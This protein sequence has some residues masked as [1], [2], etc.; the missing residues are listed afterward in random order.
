[1]SAP[2]QLE[3]ESENDETRISNITKLSTEAIDLIAVRNFYEAKNRLNKLFPLLEMELEINRSLLNKLGRKRK[4]GDGWTKQEYKVAQIEFNIDR[5][6]R[7]YKVSDPALRINGE[8]LS[9]TIE[10][11]CRILNT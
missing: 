3:L 6:N 7:L 9:Q 4:P 8:R 10:E 1:M 11:L 5:F 2:I